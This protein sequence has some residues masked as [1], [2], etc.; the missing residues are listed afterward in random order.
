MLGAGIG[1]LGIGPLI[2]RHLLGIRDEPA[3]LDEVATAAD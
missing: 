3:G 2:T 1:V